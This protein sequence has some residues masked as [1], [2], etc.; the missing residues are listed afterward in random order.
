MFDRGGGRL[1]RLDEEEPGRLCSERVPADPLC[2]R[3]SRWAHHGPRC[4]VARRTEASVP[5]GMI[6]R[7]FTEATIAAFTTHSS[8]SCVSRT[9]RSTTDE[10][11]SSGIPRSMPSMDRTADARTSGSACQVRWTRRS[12]TAARAT[13]GTASSRARNL[14]RSLAATRGTNRSAI[15]KT[16]SLT[17]PQSFRDTCRF[18]R[19]RDRTA[20]AATC[21]FGSVAAAR[22]LSATLA[23]SEAGMADQRVPKVEMAAFRT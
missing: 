5:R 22:S 10:R 15:S 9:S 6:S 11:F 23:R 1:P 19:R 17:E 14:A 8:G 21:S 16:R 2:M 20:A 3:R 4:T 13:A 12:R 18:A 7:K